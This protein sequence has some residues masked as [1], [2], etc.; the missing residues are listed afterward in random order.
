MRGLISTVNKEQEV[1]TLEIA[2]LCYSHVDVFF[3]LTV[4]SFKK[5]CYY[6]HIFWG[7]YQFCLVVVI[8]IE[9][10]DTLILA[11]TL[12]FQHGM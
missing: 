6:Y 4:L 5:Y 11:C 10:E 9:D 1:T 2:L 8:Q 3:P 12:V 7:L